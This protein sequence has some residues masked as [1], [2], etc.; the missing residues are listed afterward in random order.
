MVVVVVEGLVVVVEVEGANLDI[1]VDRVPSDIAG[2]EEVGDTVSALAEM[3]A[4]VI[5]VAVRV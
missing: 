1:F 4:A 3:R 2:D 5:G